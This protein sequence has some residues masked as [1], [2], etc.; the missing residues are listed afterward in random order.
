[1]VERLN[2]I[3][4][5]L[6]GEKVVLETS[7]DDEII[8]KMVSDYK[9]QLEADFSAK[10]ERNIADKEVEIA[11]IKRFLE[12][13]KLI[14]AEKAALELANSFLS[15]ELSETSNSEET[16]EVAYAIDDVSNQHF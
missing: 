7:S 1:M 4:T 16:T 2:E 10:K 12:K 14:E 15:E 3:L 11:V 6:E 9:A 13:E 8:E 5:E